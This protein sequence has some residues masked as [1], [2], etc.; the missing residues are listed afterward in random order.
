M[1]QK[2]ILFFVRFLAGLPD[3]VKISEEYLDF[4]QEGTV[5]LRKEFS[6]TP[7]KPSGLAFGK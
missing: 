7:K 4:Q 3:D 6:H 2:S 1:V 5:I